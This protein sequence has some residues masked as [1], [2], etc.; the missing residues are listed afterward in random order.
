MSVIA[1]CRPGK[2]AWVRGLGFLLVLPYSAGVAQSVPVLGY[3]TAKNANPKRLQVFRQGLTELGD[4][5]GKNIR[6]DYREAVLDGEYCCVMG[7][8]VGRKVDIVLAANIAMAAAKT[9]STIPAVCKKSQDSS[10]RHYLKS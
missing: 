10:H 6:I 5:E 3:V 1:W 4:A 2:R 9:T 8:L 7:E